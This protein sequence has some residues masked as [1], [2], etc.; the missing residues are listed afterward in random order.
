M[1]EE[2]VD[3]L[4]LAFV[5]SIV[6]RLG[7]RGLQSP[8]DIALLNV[9]HRHILRTLC[10]EG[11]IGPD[12]GKGSSRPATQDSIDT[13]EILAHDFSE[14]SYLGPTIGWNRHG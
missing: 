10:H 2:I 11:K 1:E 12:D 6:L 3:Y 7:N 5:G 9:P 4:A 13:S 14:T 8:D